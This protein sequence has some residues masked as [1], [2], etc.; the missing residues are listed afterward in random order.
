MTRLSEKTSIKI[1]SLKVSGDLSSVQ[2]RFET[3]SGKTWSN[4]IRS[5]LPDSFF[6]QSYDNG[7]YVATVRGTVF[8]V[9][10]EKNYARAVHHGISIKNT[11]TNASTDVAQGKAVQAHTWKEVGT[12]LLDSAWEKWNEDEDVQFLDGKMKTLSENLFNYT[13]QNE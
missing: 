4:V 11:I 2:I 13:Q 3:E 6:E 8:E 7:T 5:L 12:A 9:N 1:T 10:L